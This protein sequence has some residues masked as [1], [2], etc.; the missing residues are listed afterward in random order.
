MSRIKRKCVN[1]IGSMVRRQGKENKSV[2]QNVASL[3]GW[4]QWDTDW[5][6]RRFYYYSSELK[7]KKLLCWRPLLPVCIH[8]QVICFSAQRY[9]VAVLKSMGML[10]L[11]TR[12]KHFTSISYEWCHQDI[13]GVSLFS[14]CVLF[15][16][17]NT[18][19]ISGTSL[20]LL[21]RMLSLVISGRRLYTGKAYEA[22]TYREI[23]N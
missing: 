3:C 9:I 18:S 22:S 19:I 14:S 7:D 20:C 11:N 12:K 21:P 10:L 6:E 8:I 1:K 4:L 13:G 5:R 23:S 17:P 16:L 2:I 15:L